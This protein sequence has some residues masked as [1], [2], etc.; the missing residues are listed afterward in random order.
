[1]FMFWVGLILISVLTLVSGFRRIPLIRS[2]IPKNMNSHQRLGASNFETEVQVIDEELV[3]AATEA[4][5]ILEDAAL[6][7]NGNE[8]LSIFVG[9]SVAGFVSGIA[10]LIVARVIGDKKRDG[11]FLVGTET[12]AYFGLRGVVTSLGQVVGLPRPIAALLAGFTATILS[13]EIKIVGRQA[14]ESEMMKNPFESTADKQRKSKIIDDYALLE[15]N[16]KPPRLASDSK[17]AKKAPLISLPELSQDITKWVAYGFLSPETGLPFDAAVA[18]TASGLISHA[19]YEI[20]LP[21]TKSLLSGKAAFSSKDYLTIANRFLMAGLEGGTL[22]ASYETCTTLF[23]YVPFSDILSENFSD[24]FAA[25]MT[26][27]Q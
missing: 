14:L 20:L 7:M 19:L 17:D 25:L 27:F 24:A 3:A 16:I 8:L 10:S 5:S 1:M 6:P 21:S 26:T 12:G 9:E 4:L 13:E 18:G 23:R 11:T 22:F 2:S 15:N